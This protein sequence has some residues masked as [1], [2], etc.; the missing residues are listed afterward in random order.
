[1]THLVCRSVLGSFF[2]NFWFSLIFFLL[3]C[4]LFLSLDFYQLELWKSAAPLPQ[5]P[6]LTQPFKAIWECRSTATQK[7]NDAATL[8]VNLYDVVDGVRKFEEGPMGRWREKWR[9]S[10]GDKAKPVATPSTMNSAA[11]K[12]SSNG[13]VRSSS[14]WFE[15]KA[16]HKNERSWW[17][18]WEAVFRT[19]M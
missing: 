19:S 7:M 15:N 17:R 12:M 6:D 3:F 8:A 2:C 10:K 18:K 13:R 1:M 4:F 16:A 9:T 5:M 14:K 11:S